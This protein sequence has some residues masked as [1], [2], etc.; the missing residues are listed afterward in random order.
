M[1]SQDLH[2]Q[3]LQISNTKAIIIFRITEVY[4]YTMLCLFIQQKFKALQDK[5]N[6][7]L[8]DKHCSKGRTVEVKTL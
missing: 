5:L 3:P 1:A 8:V 2:M 7:T 4:A 6:E